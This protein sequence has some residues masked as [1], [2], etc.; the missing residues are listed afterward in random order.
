MDM[1]AHAKKMNEERE[2]AVTEH[3]AACTRICKKL[4]IPFEHGLAL[5]SVA[6]RDQM[7]G[8]WSSIV[9]KSEP[10]PSTRAPLRMTSD[11]RIKRTDPT[12]GVPKA[13]HARP[14]VVAMRVEEIE[15]LG[16][17]DDWFIAD[18]QVGARSQFPQAGP[19]LPGRLFTPGGTCH[20]F[21]TETIQTAM[22]FTM[23]VH[24]VGDDPKGGLF[25]A[26]A[27]GTQARF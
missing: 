11:H 5:V 22:D 12:T 27:M 4:E 26:V 16:K 10:G 15:I 8:A 2:K 17:P 9:R 23:L 24:Y 1:E 6:M 19:P 14:Q 3:F 21:V 7:G 20:R 18:I 25:E 13:L